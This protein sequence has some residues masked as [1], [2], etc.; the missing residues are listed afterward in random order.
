MNGTTGLGK[1]KAGD[2]DRS[3]SEDQVQSND[4]W[5]AVSRHNMRSNGGNKRSRRGRGTSKV[6]SGRSRGKK[7]A[8]GHD[9]TW[10]KRAGMDRVEKEGR[11]ERKNPPSLFLPFSLSPLFLSLIHTNRMLRPVAFLLVVLACATIAVALRPSTSSFPFSLFD[12]P[13]PP[14]STHTSLSS[15]CPLQWKTRSRRCEPRSVR[16]PRRRL[17]LLLSCRLERASSRSSNP[18]GC[19]TTRSR[20]PV[21]MPPS[22]SFKSSGLN[23]V[24]QM[25]HSLCRSALLTSLFALCFFQMM[26]ISV[27]HRR[28]VE[29][30]ELPTCGGLVDE[31]CTPCPDGGPANFCKA[32]REECSRVFCAPMCKVL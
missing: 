12:L 23:P 5:S 19:R 2:G 27:V 10:K 32:M 4:N 1:K 7:R 18:R 11:R 31:L 3:T 16:R 22:S 21:S 26:N 30:G 17:P 29:Q 6:G 24:P 25:R 14:F 28:K 20:E 13:L 9:M 8:N 15:S